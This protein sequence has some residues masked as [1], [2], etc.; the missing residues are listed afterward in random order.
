[1]TV[2]AAWAIG[3]LPDSIIAADTASAKEETRPPLRQSQRGPPGEEDGRTRTCL[4]PKVL[5]EEKSSAGWILGIP[6]SLS[7]PLY[8]VAV[9]ITGAGGHT[10][11]AS[12]PFCG[13]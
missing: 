5:S 10:I 6:C 8:P 9:A 13:P 7:W 4:S 2:E 12:I 1:M 11:V 3:A